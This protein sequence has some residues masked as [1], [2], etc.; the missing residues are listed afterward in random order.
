IENATRA[1]SLLNALLCDAVRNYD[2]KTLTT[3][4]GSPNKND[5][6]PKIAAI[7]EVIGNNAN[8]NIAKPP[9]FTATQSQ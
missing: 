5:Q 6:P 7:G 8:A 1:K 2:M 3:Q 9:I 4:S